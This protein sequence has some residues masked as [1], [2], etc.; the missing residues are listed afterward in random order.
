MMALPRSFQ[1]VRFRQIGKQRRGSLNSQQGGVQVSNN[2]DLD[3]SV[4]CEH[5]GH[6]F[7]APSQV[8]NNSDLDKLVNS[9]L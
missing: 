1:Q 9:P 6:D 4:N 8:S 3:K 5:Y 2:S 7:E